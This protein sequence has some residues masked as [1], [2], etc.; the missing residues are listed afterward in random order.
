M[1]VGDCTQ[2]GLADVDDRPAFGQ[3]RIALE[4]ELLQ[5]L[6]RRAVL[7]RAA[8]RCFFGS[9]GPESQLTE[10][11]EIV[12]RA[13]FVVKPSSRFYVLA[14]R[15]HPAYLPDAVCHSQLALRS[16]SSMLAL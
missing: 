8:L 7:F 5:R 6:R 4:L 2:T 11:L 15:D 13:V 10:Q 9:H 16:V 14:R 1:R 3:L 12:G